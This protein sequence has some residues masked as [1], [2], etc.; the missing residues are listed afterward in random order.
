[1]R[2]PLLR[3]A[4]ES[5]IAEFRIPFEAVLVPVSETGVGA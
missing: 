5:V 4:I 2:I 3:K 1:M